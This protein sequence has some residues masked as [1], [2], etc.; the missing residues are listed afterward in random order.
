VLGEDV[1]ETALGQ[2]AVERHLAA[3][4]AVDGDARARL[5]AL[6]AAAA[7]L[8]GA[9]TDAAANALARLGSAVAVAEFVE[10]HDVAPALLTPRPRHGRGGS[11]WRS[12]R[13]RKGCPPA[14]RAGASCSGQGRSASRAGRRGGG[15]GCRSARQRASCPRS[16]P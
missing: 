7:G 2:A 1:L 12:C 4:E 5:L 15:W 10:F 8:A 6:D 11:P 14:W 13:A 3:L 16:L 9:G